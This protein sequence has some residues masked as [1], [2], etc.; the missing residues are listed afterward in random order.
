MSVR[1]KRYQHTR[2]TTAFLVVSLQMEKPKPFVQA[3]CVCER[4][5]QEPDNVVS[6]IRMVDLLTLKATQMPPDSTD[7]DHPPRT[8]IQVMDLAIVVMLKAGDLTGTFTI[9]VVME[10]PNKTRVPI[11]AESPVILKGDDG[12]NALL[13]FGLP[14]NA[15]EGRY[16]FDVLWSGEVLTRIPLRLKRAEPEVEAASAKTH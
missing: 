14:Y 9:S 4:A 13:K 11:L 3:A 12:V 2:L 7:P 8:I 10:D 6:V 16:W 15:P 1:L 5:L